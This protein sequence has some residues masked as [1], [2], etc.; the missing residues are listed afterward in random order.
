MELTTIYTIIIVAEICRFI[1][2]RVRSCIRTNA[3]IRKAEAAR[4]LVQ[5][6]TTNMMGAITFQEFKPLD[7]EARYFAETA[8]NSDIPDYKWDAINMAYRLIA[9]R[10]F[11]CAKKPETPARNNYTD[12]FV[13][14]PNFHPNPVPDINIRQR[15][16]FDC[17]KPVDGDCGIRFGANINRPYHFDI[18]SP[19]NDHI[20]QYGALLRDC[21]IGPDWMPIPK[22]NR[23]LN[24]DKPA[25]NEFIAKNTGDQTV[26]CQC[27]DTCA[28]NCVICAVN[29]PCKAD[30]ITNLNDETTEHMDA[31]I[32]TMVCENCE[33]D[34]SEE[35]IPPAP[36]RVPPTP[37]V[38]TEEP[39]IETIVDPELITTREPRF[40]PLRRADDSSNV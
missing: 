25:L 4:S 39:T 6:V 30:Q 21:D 2:G 29:G 11:G 7:E 14:Y 32:Y 27:D 24:R 8:T 23:H 36:T 15:V 13:P 40:H 31:A 22:T 19:T 35:T 20:K 5:S 16:P 28:N 1:Y 33:D 17:S 12:K 9:E 34:S 3:R 38:T 26:Y 37:P 10:Y 18:P